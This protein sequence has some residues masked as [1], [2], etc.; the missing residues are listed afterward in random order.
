M[1]NC[2]PKL[3]I[4]YLI[5]NHDSK[6]KCSFVN[7]RQ[8][9]HA[10]VCAQ[11]LWLQF[12]LAARVSW[13]LAF[14]KCPVTALYI[15]V[16]WLPW[17]WSLFPCTLLEISKLAGLQAFGCVAE[18]EIIFI[19]ISASILV[20]DF[21]CLEVSWLA[22]FFFSFMSVTDEL[23]SVYMHDLVW[24]EF[25][26]R[27]AC[28]VLSHLAYAHQ[29]T[30]SVDG[31]RQRPVSHQAKCWSK[32]LFMNNVFQF[33]LHR[34]IV[35]VVLGWCDEESVGPGLSASWAFNPGLCI[36]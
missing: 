4:M 9:V 26:K 6:H 24:E 18:R 17:V 13:S 8:H 21:R 5:N 16:L 11:G 20:Q 27:E 36:I 29:F 32:L 2:L 15:V 33:W 19:T 12:V 31:Q 14:C 35:D 3:V 1:N 25:A 22:F 7:A 34:L 28:E 30:F 23:G 10:I